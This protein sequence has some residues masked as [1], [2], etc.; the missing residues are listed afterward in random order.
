[1][2][3]VKARWRFKFECPTRSSFA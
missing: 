1:M 3:P 2:F